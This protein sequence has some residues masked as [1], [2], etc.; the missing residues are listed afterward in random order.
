MRGEVSSHSGAT[1]V[2][3]LAF[4]DEVFASPGLLEAFAETVSGDD[5]ITLYVYAPDSESAALSEKLAPVLA[6]T[7]LDRDGSPEIVGLAVPGDP[8]TRAT[9]RA[10][11]DCL[12]SSLGPPAGFDDVPVVRDPSGLV[13]LARRVSFVCNVCD[14]HATVEPERIGRETPSCPHCRSTVRFRAVANAV[15]VGLFGRTLP[16]SAF[17]KRKDIV[18]LGLSDWDGYAV[19]LAEKLGYRNTY[20][21]TEPRL[22]ILDPDPA[23]EG[24]LDFLVST[25]VFE[26]VPPPIERA[27]VNTAR[28]LKPGGF[29]V[30]TVP[31]TLADEIDEHFPELHDWEIVDEGGVRLLRNTTVDGRT[32]EFRDLVFHGGDGLT[33]EMRLCALHPLL[34]LLRASGFDDVRVLRDDVPAFGIVQEPWGSWPI[35]A[36][37]S[38]TVPRSDIGGGHDVKKAA[39]GLEQVPGHTILPRPAGRVT[40]SKPTTSSAAAVENATNAELIDF[41]RTFVGTLGTIRERLGDARR[42]EGDL[43]AD[44]ELV[45]RALGDDGRQFLGL[46]GGAPAC[47]IGARSGDLALMLASLGSEV[48]LVVDAATGQELLEGIGRLRAALGLPISLAPASLDHRLDLPRATYGL[49]CFLD[50]LDHLQNPFFALGALADRARFCLLTAGIADDTSGG[51]A[52][53]DRPL[54]YL[55]TPEAA[56]GEMVDRYWVFTDGGLRRVVGRAGWDIVGGSTIDVQVSPDGAGGPDLRAVWLLRSRRV[57]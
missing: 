14:A 39:S 3:A 6:R 30:L 44:L 19:P 34:E 32:Q 22:D 36:R 27:L 51:E 56:G 24:T 8:E 53:Q 9:I 42:A 43:V 45:R 12:W 13:A 50:V 48:D 18:G 28:L 57:A 31:Y 10:Q 52:W 23:L 29:L 11:I 5:P 1:S 16:L 38:P 25:E 55:T 37:K 46:V 2:A 47:I 21:H 20:L 4:A 26:H 35:L 15:S 7:G 17:P 33:L 54:A 40:I 41:A 49:A